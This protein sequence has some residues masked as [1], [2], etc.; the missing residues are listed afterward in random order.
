MRIKRLFTIILAVATTDVLYAQDFHLSQYDAAPMYFNP[1]ETGVFTGLLS[2]KSDYRFSATYRSQWRMLTNKPF[3]TANLAFDMPYKRFGIGGFLLNN[4]S[5]IGNFNTLH[6]LI[7][8]TYH[9]IKQEENTPHILTTGIQLGFFNKSFNPN[10]FTFDNQ[11]TPN[12]FDSNISN[13][14]YFDRLGKMNFD[15]NVGFFYKYNDQQNKAK[16]FL[17]GS[18]YHINRPNESFYNYGTKV[19]MRFVTILGTEVKLS[20]KSNIQPQFMYMYESAAR[21]VNIGILGTYLFK[22]PFN[23]MYGVS[24]RL[25]DAIIVQTGIKYQNMV[26]RFS[27]DYNI[28]YL[29]KYTSGR[30]AMEFTLV[31]FHSKGK[32]I[33][34]RSRI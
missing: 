23:L 14:E 1:A 19:P 4:K 33:I 17:G 16:P 15:L 8:G 26:I 24:Y 27:Y 5:G 20:N 30:G 9:I 7:G 25:N 21:E 28:S 13:E 6:F 10:R 34:P 32:P 3:T 11:Y 31:L 22:E 2:E 18:I 29:K 12:G